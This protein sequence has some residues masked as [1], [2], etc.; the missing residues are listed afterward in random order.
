MS[1][2]VSTR[3]DQAQAQRAKHCDDLH[4]PQPRPAATSANVDGG[5][6]VRTTA[7]VGPQGHT[8]EPDK[9]NRHNNLRSPTPFSTTHNN[10]IVA[11]HLPLPQYSKSPIA[12]NLLGREQSRIQRVA[13]ATPAQR[14]WQRTQRKQKRCPHPNAPNSEAS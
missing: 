9:G 4:R 13:M 6:R 5:A 7:Y 2:C 8:Q 14:P 12:D 1:T 10:S 3:D 11:M